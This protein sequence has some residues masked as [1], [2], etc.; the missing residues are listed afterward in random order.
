MNI[1]SNPINP[2]NLTTVNYSSCCN[3]IT[4]QTVSG[5]NVPTKSCNTT[6]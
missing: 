5:Y 3:G 2:Y 4:G 6:K 1:I